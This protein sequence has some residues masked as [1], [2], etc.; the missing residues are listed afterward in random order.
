MFKNCFRKLNL[1]FLLPISYISSIF[2]YK[3]LYQDNLTRQK[4]KCEVVEEIDDEY[5]VADIK[6][7][8]KKYYLSPDSKRHSF[9]LFTGNGNKELAQEVAKD[10]K[11]SLGKVSMMKLDNGESFIKVH[12]TVSNRNIIIIQS[13][14]PPIND[15]LMELLF[16]ISA[17]KRES[18]KK[19]IVVIPY[20]SYSRKLVSGIG[21]VA[22]RPASV[23]VRLLEGLGVDQV[24]AIE[25]HSKP[26]TG[27]SM[28]MPIIDLDM[29]YVGASYLIEKMAKG[30]IAFN[31][32]I[33][34]PDVNGA[35]RARKMRDILELNGIPATLGFISDYKGSDG[36]T[37]SDSSRY[38]C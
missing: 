5:Y 4:M 25:L 38:Y 11:A 7:F 9:I 21:K 20:F 28:S 19:I 18:A 12:E 2:I 1:Q 10:L 26:I 8:M 15:N 24:I 27:F 23:I 32:V 29:V 14:S 36:I 35:V 34:S 22:P 37:K 30:E 13:L 33:V 17:L 3:R 6:R 16:L 31:P